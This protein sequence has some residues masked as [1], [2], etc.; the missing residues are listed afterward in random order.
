MIT[1]IV[2]LTQYRFVILFWRVR[3]LKWASGVDR[4]VFL[5]ETRGKLFSLLFQLLEATHIPWLLGLPL[6]SKPAV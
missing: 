5:L 6:S 1:N 4:A 3:T 2:V